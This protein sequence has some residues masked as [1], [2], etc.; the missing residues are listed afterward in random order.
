MSGADRA[1][2]IASNRRAFH[3]Y[4]V[5]ERLEAG[6]VLVGTEVKALRAGRINLRDGFVR[7]DGTGAWLES[8]HISQ[9]EQG[10]INNHEPTRARR[11]LLHRRELSWLVGKVRQQGITLIPLR[12]YFS[13]RR[14]KVELGLCK[15]K[16]LY[17][18]RAS[19]REAEARR[20]IDRVLKSRR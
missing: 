12:V 5:L 13:G 4:F 2:D 9:Y 1:A 17:D 8:V 15:G 16:K 11:L 7:V 20:E 14:I 3:E 10:N 6:I 18:K 19:L